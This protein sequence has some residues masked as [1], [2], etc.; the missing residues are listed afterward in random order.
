MWENRR[1]G[2]DPALVKAFINLLGIYPVGTCVILDTYELAIVHAANPSLELSNRP[3]VRIISTPDGATL[4]QGPIVDLAETNAEGVLARSIVKV[5][6]PAKYGIN[7]SD[8][9]V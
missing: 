8:Y 9:F 1:R 4:D 7:P 2:L 3:L 6:N 5:T